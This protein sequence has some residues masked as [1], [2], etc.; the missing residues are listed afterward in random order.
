[1]NRFTLITEWMGRSGRLISTI[2]L[3][4]NM[5][6]VV[7][8]IIYRLVG[9]ALPGSYEMIEITIGATVSFA[10][11]Y[12]ALSKDHLVIDLLINRLHGRTRVVVN[13]FALVVTLVFLA[14]MAWA[15]TGTVAERLNTEE[16]Q[17][18]GIPV[19][20]FRIMWVLGLIVFCVVVIRDIL[21]SFKEVVKK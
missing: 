15:G 7:A 17:T 10:L 5:V 6:I 16:T 19:M 3:L 21:L 18:L 1:M 20:P 4:L 11:C 12:A 9:G 13:I 2:F 14:W 8:S